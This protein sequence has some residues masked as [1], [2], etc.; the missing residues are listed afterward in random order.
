MCIRDRS[1]SYAQTHLHLQTYKDGKIVNPLNVLS[2]SIKPGTGTAE[3][4]PSP[5]EGL[6]VTKVS[7]GKVDPSSAPEIAP[8]S[9]GDR[10]TSVIPVSGSNQQQPSQSST[11]AGQK[12]VPSFSS[13][14]MGN[15]EFIVI[16][17]IYNIVG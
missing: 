16:K 3:V 12:E 13:R 14:D 8:P 9:S 6:P 4:K 1:N 2:G 10:N 17:S 15:T 5:Q 11:S 7:I